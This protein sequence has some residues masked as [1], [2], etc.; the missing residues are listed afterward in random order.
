MFKDDGNVLHFASP[1]GEFCSSFLWVLLFVGMRI[2]GIRVGMWMD[3]LDG[4]GNDCGRCGIVF[5]FP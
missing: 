4:T 1:R 5:T 3:G 2:G